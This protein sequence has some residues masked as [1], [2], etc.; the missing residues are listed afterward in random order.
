ML[1]EDVMDLMCVCKLGRK[2]ILF[3]EWRNGVSKLGEWLAQYYKM[4]SCMAW[5]WLQGKIL[6]LKQVTFLFEGTI[7]TNKIPKYG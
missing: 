5:W 4:G 2:N 3:I 1:V 7:G 6:F